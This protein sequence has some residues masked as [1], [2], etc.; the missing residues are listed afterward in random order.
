LSE[1]REDEAFIRRYLHKDSVDLRILVHNLS[2]DA[3]SPAKC[4]GE[5]GAGPPRKQD[6]DYSAQHETDK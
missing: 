6:S 5:I 2:F 3:T 1:S 4:L